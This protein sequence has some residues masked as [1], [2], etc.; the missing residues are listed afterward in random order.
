MEKA[1]PNYHY[2]V[3]QVPGLSEEDKA[4]FDQLCRA[5][6]QRTSDRLKQ[7]IVEDIEAHASEIVECEPVPVGA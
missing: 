1:H 5:R 4:R 3:N 2:L 6:F 7:L